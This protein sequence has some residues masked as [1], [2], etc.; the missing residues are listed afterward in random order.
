M[1]SFSLTRR[2]LRVLACFALTMT[3]GCSLGMGSVGSRHEM[4]KVRGG[5][6]TMAPGWYAKQSGP[7][8]T[9][10]EWSEG[11]TVPGRSW[12]DPGG[13]GLGFGLKYGIAAPR[14]ATVETSTDTAWDVY[15]VL[16]AAPWTFAVG[17]G[18]EHGGLPDLEGF[19]VNVD[20]STYFAEVGRHLYF[21]PTPLGLDFVAVLGLGSGKLDSPMHAESD[22]V[23]TYRPGLRMLKTL[24]TTNASSIVLVIEGRYTYSRELTFNEG[25]FNYASPTLLAEIA[26]R[27]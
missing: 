27:I 6:Y 25:T 5:S 14:I 10:Y 26:I 19:D 7:L 9:T 1:L 24:R 8:W 20:F 18:V 3:T 4:P 2:A 11:G 21:L 12:T 13:W 15:G 16:H 17:W 22:R 23:L